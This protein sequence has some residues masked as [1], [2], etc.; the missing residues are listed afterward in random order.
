MTSPILASPA[1]G[2]PQISGQTRRLAVKEAHAREIDM[3]FCS[4]RTQPVTSGAN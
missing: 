2:L 3:L 1:V 4:F